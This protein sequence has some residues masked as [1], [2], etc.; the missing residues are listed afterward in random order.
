MNLRSFTTTGGEEEEEEEDEEPLLSGSGQ[1]A[2]TTCTD[3]ELQS[4][5]DVLQ[6]WKDGDEH[7]PEK[8]LQ[9]VRKVNII[10]YMSQGLTSAGV[11]RNQISF[12]VLISFSSKNRN[13]PLSMSVF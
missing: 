6:E 9:L 3:E 10:I 4:W 8:V 7:R 2:H 11:Q 1:V 12:W 13:G 5:K